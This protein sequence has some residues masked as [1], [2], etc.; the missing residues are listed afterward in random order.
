[1]RV[2]CAVLHA[3]R[4]SFSRAGVAEPNSAETLFPQFPDVRLVPLELRLNVVLPGFLIAPVQGH[5]FKPWV[6]PK[7][8]SAP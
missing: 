2:A 6:L 5:L 4:A 3:L 8:D 1:M 7:V